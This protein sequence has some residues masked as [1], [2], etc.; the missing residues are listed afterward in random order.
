MDK[1]LSNRYRRVI[2]ASG[3]LLGLKGVNQRHFSIDIAWPE[4]AGELILSSK[5]R[6]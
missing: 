6:R 3:H 2:L 4:Y 1:S 5:F